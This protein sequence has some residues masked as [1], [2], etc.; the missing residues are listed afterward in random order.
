MTRELSLKGILICLI[1][2]SLSL[3][4]K[5]EPLLNSNTAIKVLLERDA[6][7]AKFFSVEHAVFVKFDGASRWTKLAKEITVSFSKQGKEP[8]VAVSHS[9]FNSKSLII[10]GGPLPK[11]RISFRD[12]TYRGAIKVVATETGFKAVNIIP[13]DDYLRGMLAS[14][15]SPSWPIEALKAQAVTSRT[16]ALYMINHPKSEEYDLEKTTQDQVYSGADVEAD[17][18]H[19]ALEAT[20]NEYLESDGMPIKSYF[21]SRCGGTTETAESVWNYKD[22]THEKR[23]PCPYCQRNPQKWNVLVK[24]QDILRY[25]KL[26]E[27]KAVELKAINRS[28]SGRISSLKIVSGK[29]EKKVPADYFRS[30]IGY[31]RLKSTK[32]TWKK[33]GDDIDFEGVGAGHGVGMCQWGAKYL[34]EQKKS[35]RE[36]LKHY[37]PQATLH[38][39]EMAR[40]YY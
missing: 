21:H 16:Y 18:V 7:S 36:I 17:K 23:V 33:S 5:D 26:P 11:D 4:G 8:T 27:A 10:R 37:Y 39:M 3:A 40:A 35:Y 14:E 6:Q 12:N 32:F 25:F 1:I 9:P 38:R 22:K 2:S 34:A 31:T 28:P 30:L 13:L 19:E 29:D 20:K 15:M 24:A